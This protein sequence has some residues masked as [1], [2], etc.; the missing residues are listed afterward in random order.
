M[1]KKTKNIIITEHK[2]MLDEYCHRWAHYFDPTEVDD[3]FKPNLKEMQRELTS[4][5]EE[6]VHSHEIAIFTLKCKLAKHEKI[7][8]NFFIKLLKQIIIVWQRMF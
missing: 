1:K 3:L 8:D 5:M 2:A 7:D 6:I 4:T